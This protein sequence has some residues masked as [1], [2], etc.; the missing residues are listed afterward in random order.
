MR[1]DPVSRP[2]DERAGTNIPGWQ[3]RREGN[4]KVL[5]APIGD[6]LLTEAHTD[7][8]RALAAELLKSV[9]RYDHCRGALQ[10]LRHCAN[11]SR[12]VYSARIV[13]PGLHETGLDAFGQNLRGALGQ[14]TGDTLP[15]RS[16]LFAQ[17][18][19]T[20]GGKAYLASLSATSALCGRIDAGFDPG[21]EHGSS[22]RESTMGRLLASLMQQPP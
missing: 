12:L 16:W 10:L 20:H 5:G 8:R 11:W 19:I 6:V 22:R 3:W 4:F 15:E 1:G 7:E 13:P 14:L 17:L 21:D 2:V 18:G 9:G